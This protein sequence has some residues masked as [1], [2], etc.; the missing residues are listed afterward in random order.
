MLGTREIRQYKR[1][2]AIQEQSDVQKLLCSAQLKVERLTK[3][4]KTQPRLFIHDHN[5]LHS[6]QHSSSI[7]QTH[8]IND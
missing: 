3:H 4:L 6:I 2:I 5:R 7:S 8:D 1:D